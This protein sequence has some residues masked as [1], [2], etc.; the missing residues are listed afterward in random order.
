MVQRVEPKSADTETPA[1]IQAPAP[2]QSVAV[3][4]VHTSQWDRLEAVAEVD[5]PTVRD[6]VRDRVTK[7]TVVS[8]AVDCDSVCEDWQLDQ[9]LT[10]D[11]AT[12]RFLIGPQCNRIITCGKAS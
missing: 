3:D 8:T 11:V 12:I 2:D 9:I 7:Y 4:C 6:R 1:V 10:D 5:A